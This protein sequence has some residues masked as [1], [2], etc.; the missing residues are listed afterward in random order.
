MNT[1]RHVMVCVYI[2]H[3]SWEKQEWNWCFCWW[4]VSRPIVGVV[5]HTD[6]L[7]HPQS[8]NWPHI[9][10]SVCCILELW[11]IVTNLLYIPI[12]WFVWKMAKSLLF[13][14]DA[15]LRENA[16]SKSIL[17][18]YT[19]TVSWMDLHFTFCWMKSKITGD[20]DFFATNYMT[21]KSPDSITFYNTNNY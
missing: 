21:I 1:L 6:D 18:M 20:Q 19:N 7:S 16:E 5:N 2:Q 17:I 15:T 9:D 11:N 3:V 12:E 13:Q 14:T 8:Y 4:T 10:I